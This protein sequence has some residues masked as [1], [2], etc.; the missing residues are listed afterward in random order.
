M[1]PRLA[2]ALT[3]LTRRT[4]LVTGLAHPDD[5][6]AAKE[7]FVRLH[8]AGEALNMGEVGL[9]ALAL[10]WDERDAYQLGC[11]AERIGRG[12]R[13]RIRGGPWWNNRIFVSPHA[14]RLLPLPR[15]QKHHPAPDCA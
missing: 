8:H 4:N 12:S 13:V 2:H 3:V 11:L 14:D 1:T 5:M 7:L 9:L 6:N 15:A 10:G